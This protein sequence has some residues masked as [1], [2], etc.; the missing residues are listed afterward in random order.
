MRVTDWVNC[1]MTLPVSSYI[2][3]LLSFPHSGYVND[4]M[5]IKCELDQTTW[6]SEKRPSRLKKGSTACKKCYIAT[7]LSA[8]TCT[9]MFSVSI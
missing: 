1:D 7:H 4:N 8:D 5:P 6:F 3:L 9:A 2:S